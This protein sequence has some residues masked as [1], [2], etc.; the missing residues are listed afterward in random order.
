MA[1]YL[2]SRESGEVNIPIHIHIRQVILAF[3][4]IREHVTSNI[5][6]AYVVSETFNNHVYHDDN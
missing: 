4:G 3:A 2:P 1:K 5:V 6:C